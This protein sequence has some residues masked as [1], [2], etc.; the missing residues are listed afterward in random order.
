MGVD[1]DHDGSDVPEES[2]AGDVNGGG[3]ADL[4]VGAPNDDINS[5]QSNQ[6]GDGA[7]PFTVPFSRPFLL[8]S[9]FRWASVEMDTVG[10]C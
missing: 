2:L 8:V 6:K 4:I 9:A 3:Y 10:D 1:A 7:S 5:A